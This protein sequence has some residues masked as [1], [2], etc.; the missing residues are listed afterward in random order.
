[1]KKATLKILFALLLI[2]SYS[3]AQVEKDTL[4]PGDTLQVHEGDTL[5]DHCVICAGNVHTFIYAP[6]YTQF[7]KQWP[8]LVGA[9]AA[10]AAGFI[11]AS[12]NKHDPLTEAEVQSLDRNSV[13]SFDRVSTRY[14][15]TTAGKASDYV[16]FGIGLLPVVFLSEHHTSVDMVPLAIM[17]AE[18]Y[19]FN[20]GVTTI[21]KNLAHRTRPYVYNT[22]LPLETKLGSGA[23]ESFFSGH[24]S[25]TAAATFLF[26]NVIRDYHPNMKPGIKTGMWVFAATVPAVEGYLRM[27]AGKHYPSDVIAGYVIGA[28]SGWAIPRLHRYQR[29]RSNKNKVDLGFLPY[30]DGMMMSIGYRF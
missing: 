8:F 5:K 16:L 21:A 26:A 14:W 19:L 3:Q 15:S 23:R 24:T 22:D 9:S 12:T 20:Y 4:T 25:Q 11:L 1:M 13:N 18:A 2:S 10:Y 27:R 29:S 28:A 6:Y 7:K 17:A 30:K